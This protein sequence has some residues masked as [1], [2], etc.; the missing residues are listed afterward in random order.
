M[1]RR[2]KVKKV[3]SEPQ[4]ARISAIK[5]AMLQMSLSEERATL[6]ILQKHSAASRNLQNMSVRI[7]V[8]SADWILGQIQEVQALHKSHAT[9]CLQM[10]M[11]RV[12]A[13]QTVAS[14]RSAA[15]ICCGPAF[16]CWGLETG[17]C[18]Q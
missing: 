14:R 9:F 10:V 13:L 1:S 18:L 5:P 11:M 8:F 4:L 15:Y 12:H 6:E 2:L 3:Q 16:G 7:T 17:E